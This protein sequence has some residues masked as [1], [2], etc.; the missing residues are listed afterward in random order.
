MRRCT[1]LIGV[2]VC[3]GVVA[4]ATAEDPDAARGQGAGQVALDYS[5]DLPRVSRITIGGI[6]YDRITMSGCTSGGNAGEPALPARGSRILL[7]MGAEIASVEVVGEPVS[8]GDGYLVEPLSRPVKLSSDP[9]AAVPPTPDPAIYETDVI[10]P[11]SAFEEIGTNGFR[12]YQILT[13]KLHPVT[14]LPTTGELA[15]YPHLTVIVHTVETDRVSA[16]FR[17]LARDERDVQTKVDNVVETASYPTFSGRDGRGYE[18]LIITT[19]SL[20]GAFQPLVDYHNA[21]GIPTEIHTTTEIGGSDPDTIRAYITD[22]YNNDGISYVIIGA[23]D[24]IIPAKDL[25]VIIAPGDEY[26]LNM[27]GDI[28]FACLDGTY[29]YDGDSRWGEPT[30]GEGGGDVDLVAEVYVGRASVGN[31]TEATRF[32]NKTIWYLNN[33]H[34]QPEKVLLVGEYLGFGGVADYAADTLEELID[35]CITHGYTTVGIPSS[36]YTIDELFERDMSW[37]Q[38]TLVSRIN[39]GVH[40]LNHLGHGSPDYA[41]KLYNSDVTSDLTNDDLCFVYS[42]TCSAGHFDGTDCWAETMN[43]KTDHG[44]F[45]VIMN[46]R[47]GFGE[48]YSTDGPSQRFN[49]EFWDAVFDEGM[50]E[51]GRAN[52]DSKEDNLYRINEDC[53]RW[54]T[55]E[56]NLFGDPTVAI[57]GGLRVSPAG[58]FYSGGFLGGPFTPVSQDY[59]LQN[60]NATPLSYQVTVTQPWLS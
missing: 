41:M 42:Q 51:L 18:L 55:Y 23:D 7:P 46:A 27:P 24:D 12:G 28:Y 32:V 58:D 4:V 29:N 22:R 13:L 39:S 47:Y 25:Y 44:G 20:A 6:E 1:L 9:A 31:T 48:Y 34:T 37:S 45:A 38:S 14:Y 3:A 19:T 54:C 5:F 50:P 52:Q 8:L 21:H 43:I 36:E 17:G 16:L 60:L 53:M 40:F 26:E 30:D 15:Y 56:L 10:F 57:Q 11:S 35:G 33:Q 2:I 59:L 49:R